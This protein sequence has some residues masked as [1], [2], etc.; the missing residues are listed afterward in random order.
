MFGKVP[1]PQELIYI[2]FTQVALLNITDHHFFHVHVVVFNIKS[3]YKSSL[4][5]CQDLDLLNKVLP[6]D[7][8]YNIH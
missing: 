4:F 1:Q 2:F 5:P 6:P 7:G 3:V 8:N